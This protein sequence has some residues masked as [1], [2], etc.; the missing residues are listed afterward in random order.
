LDAD[1]GRGLVD[2]VS[3]Y[4]QTFL[5]LQ[6]YDEGLLT[7]PQAQAGGKLPSVEEA[8]A[9]LDSLKGELIARG[10]ATE[11]FARDRAMAW[12]RCWATWTRP[13]SANR[14]TP[15]WRQRRHICCTL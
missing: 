1:S 14:P 6:R 12:L 3:R 5:L 13:S 8:R 7:D 2:I 4:A 9:G 11:L 15:V 10:E